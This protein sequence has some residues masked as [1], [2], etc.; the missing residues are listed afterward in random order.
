MAGDS[1]VLDRINSN[2]RVFIKGI[3]AG[4]AFAVPMMMSFD[5]DTMAVHVGTTAYASGG[6]A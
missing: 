1:K 5:M 3:V 2:K 4:T 6:T